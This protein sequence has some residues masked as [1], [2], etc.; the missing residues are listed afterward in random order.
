[1]PV[2]T[3][4]LPEQAD[5]DRFGANWQVQF[6]DDKGQP[7]NMGSFEAI[8]FGAIAYKEIFQNVKTILATPLFS[9]PLER[10]L[11]ID[12]S[13]VD[14]PINLA[15]AATIAILEAINQ[16]EPRAEIVSVEFDPDV[17]TGHL[18]VNVQ[19]K[20]KNLIY[21][22]NTPYPTNNVFAAPPTTIGGLPIM[23]IPVPG[24]PGPPGPQGPAGVATIPEP[25]N[26]GVLNVGTT[27][28]IGDKTRITA[29]SNGYRV[30][31]Q[32]SSGTWVIEDEKTE[33]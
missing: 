7:L 32:N 31:V 12:Q 2:I 5:L 13:V 1:M 8:D 30:E 23:N 3:N 4:V 27:V 26:V 9:C 18:G 15:T 17:L 14:D 28:K 22:T 20:V 21:G 11:G 33:S 25:L 10:T 24:P 29:L 19:L 16:W 6:T